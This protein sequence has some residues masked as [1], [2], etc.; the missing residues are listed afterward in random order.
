MENQLKGIPKIQ[1]KPRAA[2]DTAI[3]YGYLAFKDINLSGPLGLEHHVQPE[4]S[5][6]YRALP[7]R[8]LVPFTNVLFAEIDEKAAATTSYSPRTLPIV[9]RQKNAKECVEEI[10]A[11]YEEWGFVHLAPLVGFSEE[12]AFLV[13][14]TI[15]PFTYKLGDLLDQ[16]EYGATDRINETAPHTAVYNGQSFTLQ[17][18]PAD[19]KDVARQVQQI[20]I[21]SVEVA[22]AK[23]EDQRERTVQSMTQYFSTGQGKRRADP[24]DQYIFD[25][26]NEPLPRLV[27]GKEEKDSG[28]GIIEKLADAI[29]GKQKQEE[30]DRELAELRAL[31]DQL[32]AATAPAE[33][34]TIEQTA[35][36]VAIGD[37]VVVGGQEATVTA[38]PFG[39]V[40]VQFSDGSARTVAKDEI[41]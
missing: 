14:Q 4:G 11:S 10:V 38:K 37:V 7:C 31:K 6:Y 21:K 30:V 34:V 15:Q 32:Q 12:D 23:G 2:N 19:L 25:Q 40:K 13:F 33:P 27:G 22:V 3:H 28:V 36:T 5:P 17:P 41:E 29:M 24:L 8:E 26:F 9:Q 18:L 20:I 35:K 16:V 1:Q 39:K